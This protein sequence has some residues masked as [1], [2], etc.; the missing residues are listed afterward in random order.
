MIVLLT[1]INNYVFYK[2]F[3]GF[4]LNSNYN[5]VYILNYIFTQVFGLFFFKFNCLILS[6]KINKRI[7]IVTI[8]ID[9]P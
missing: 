7:K 8:T 1:L 9:N 4:D 2:L 5:F 6:G 3:T